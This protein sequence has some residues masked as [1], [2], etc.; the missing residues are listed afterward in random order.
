MASYGLSTE[1][2]PREVRGARSSRLEKS[3]S[4]RKSK[5]SKRSMQV[6]TDTDK[7]YSSARACPSR[8]TFS[9]VINLTV[10]RIKLSPRARFLLPFHGETRADQI[11]LTRSRAC[12][13]A[14]RGN[15]SSHS[16]F[17]YSLITGNMQMHGCSNE[18][19]ILGYFI[20]RIKFRTC[21]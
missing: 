4:K 12:I 17:V 20:R 10:Y 2:L 14:Y 21:N 3:L 15:H 6:A 13:R 18:R 5:Q 1:K 9:R 11:V 19:N 16:S 8:R 7:S